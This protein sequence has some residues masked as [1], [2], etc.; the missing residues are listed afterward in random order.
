MEIK[1]VGSQPSGNGPNSV[2]ALAYLSSTRANTRGISARVLGPGPEPVNWQV[3]EKIGLLRIFVENNPLAKFAQ[4]LGV[5][6]RLTLDGIS[7]S[8]SN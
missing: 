3:I 2:A 1:R 6:L 8:G 7:K 4:T 5:T